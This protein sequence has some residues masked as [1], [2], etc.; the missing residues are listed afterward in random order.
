MAVVKV[1]D[2]KTSAR[3][4]VSL[5]DFDDVLALPTLLSYS[6]HDGDTGTEIRAETAITP[7]S[8]F[9]IAL[10]AADNTILDNVKDFEERVVT[11]NAKYGP[12]DELH[13]AFEYK[14]RNHKHDADAI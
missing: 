14:V 3:L 2:D 5:Y 13:G 7:A 4:A 8:S 6:I 11:V 1:V 9:T 10:N 12:S